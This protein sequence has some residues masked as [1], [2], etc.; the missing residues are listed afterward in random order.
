MS[1]YLEGTVARGGV[2]RILEEKAGALRP[3]VTLGGVDQSEG[4]LGEGPECLCPALQGT[5]GICVLMF[6]SFM[7]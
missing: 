1:V 5:G 2:E 6:V 4:S 7:L 3:P